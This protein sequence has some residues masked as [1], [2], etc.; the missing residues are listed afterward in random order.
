MRLGPTSYPNP[1]RAVGAIM[2]AS[3]ASGSEA[4]MEEK[5]GE[6]AERLLGG[7]VLGDAGGSAPAGGAQGEI[8]CVDCKKQF[9][10]TDCT[11]WKKKNATGDPYATPP[12]V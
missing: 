3:D 5:L 9:C 1:G 6:Q 2:S 11:T 7:S 8:N 10:I 4:E 12:A